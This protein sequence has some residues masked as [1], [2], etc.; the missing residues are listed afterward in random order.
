M[1]FEKIKSVNQTA[2]YQLTKK[3]IGIFLGILLVMNVFYLIAA[4]GFVYEYVARRG[5]DVLYALA[6][7]KGKDLNWPVRIDS[8]VSEK[9]EDALI[10]ETT[11]GDIY[12]SEESKDVFEALYTGKTLPFIDN[13]IFSH[14]GLYYVTTK[15]YGDFKAQLAINTETAA[16]LVSGMFVISIVLNLVAII[17]G[18]WVIHKSVGKWSRKLTEMAKEITEVDVLEDTSITVPTDPIE[19][20][21]VAQAFNE[22]LEKQQN[23]IKRERQFITDASHDL[24]TPVAGIRGHVNLIKRRGESHPEIIPTSLDFIDKESARLERLTHQLLDLDQERASQSKMQLDISSLI[25]E[26]VESSHVLATHELAINVPDN[27]E[28]Y[29]RKSDMEQIIQNVLQNAMKYSDDKSLIEVTLEETNN[30]LLLKVS[31]QGIGINKEE[32]QH[33]FERFYRIDNSR[34]STVEGSGIGLAIVK[35]IVDL[36]GGSIKIEDNHP[37]GTIFSISLPKKR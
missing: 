37:K 7:E 1:F 31:D 14:E 34:T 11:Q 5:N 20:T 24:K 8:F 33:I 22:L 9:E 26:V 12:Y 25:I 29:G 13:L 27:L 36:Y 35:K 10:I 32:K 6:N 4:S 17:L 23:I 15:D 16:E 30:S 21:K 2:Q 28:Y 18:S 19:I 3:F